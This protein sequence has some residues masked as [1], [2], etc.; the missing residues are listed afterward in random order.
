MDIQ[1]KTMFSVVF[2]AIQE[3]CYKN[4]KAKGFLEGE[5][6]PGESIA[7]MHSELSEALEELRLDPLRPDKNCDKFLAVE[8]KL[9]DV[10]IRIMDF[11]EDY[12]FNLAGAILAK[13]AYNETRPFKHGGK[14][15]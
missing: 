4:A 11:A 7:L 1:A 10:I 15:F 8:T 9:A 14:L 13:M 3:E 12:E 2:K 6:N 5:R